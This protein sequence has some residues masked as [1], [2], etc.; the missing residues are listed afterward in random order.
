MDP[1]LRTV[2]VIIEVLLLAVITYS[3]LR[4]VG[5]M[6]LDLGV[7]EKYRKAIN[8]VLIVVGT[9]CVIFFFAHLFSWYPA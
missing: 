8:M 6:A 9:L 7:G 1:V 4:G 2:A 5:L 3:I